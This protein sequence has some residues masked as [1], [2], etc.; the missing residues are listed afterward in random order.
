MHALGKACV[1]SI[2]SLISFL[3]SIMR[4]HFDPSI[5][6]IRISKGNDN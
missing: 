2:L 1:S 6:V 5:T 4:T 3:L